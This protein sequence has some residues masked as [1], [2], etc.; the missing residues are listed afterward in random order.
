MDEFPWYF[1]SI[2]EYT[3]LMEEVGF[4]VIYAVYFERPSKLLGG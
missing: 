1:P 2:G 3:S 4:E